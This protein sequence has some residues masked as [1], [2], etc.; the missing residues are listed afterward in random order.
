[1]KN[2]TSRRAL[3]KVAP[4]AAAVVAA[5][6][7]AAK[8][9]IMVDTGEWEATKLAYATARDR[10]HRACE[11]EGRRD[12]EVI[13]FDKTA[14]SRAVSVLVPAQ[15]INLNGLAKG[16]YRTEAYEST[17]TLLPH[18]LEDQPAY[19]KTTEDFKQ[20]SAQLD[21]WIAERERL[22]QRRGWAA[23]V[24]EWHDACAAEED[25]W[26]ALVSCPVC[27]LTQLGEKI[28]IVRRG[29]ELLFE[30]H[31]ASFAEGIAADVARLQGRA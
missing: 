20:Y 28:D 11:A 22:A 27:D 3:L 23:I 21:V 18:N 30:E 24:Q 15:Q 6:A 1:M 14:P 9:A 31:A 10:F 29:D 8:S 5:P 7:F 13:D 16:I 26:Q 2:T 17:V 12:S 19:V 25:A 4:V